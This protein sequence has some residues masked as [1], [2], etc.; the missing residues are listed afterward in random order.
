MSWADLMTMISEEAGQAAAE[1]IARRARLEM[2]GM[3][4]TIAKR[5]KITVEHINQVAPGK[6]QEAARALGVHPR[7]IYRVLQRNRII[8]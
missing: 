3:R 8:R 2:G 6:P 1:R 7:T 4:I 5:E